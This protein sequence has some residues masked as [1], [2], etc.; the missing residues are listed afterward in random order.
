MYWAGLAD[1]AGNSE[2]EAVETCGD[3][4]VKNTQ[5]PKTRL[6]QDCQQAM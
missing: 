1:E 4:H 3:T 6:A 5:E 2:A